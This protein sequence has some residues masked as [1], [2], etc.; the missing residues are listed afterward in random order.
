MLNICS[1]TSHQTGGL[2]GYAGAE[3]RSVDIHRNTVH[4]QPTAQGH[5]AV[6]L[7]PCANHT[8]PH[9]RHNPQYDVTVHRTC[10]GQE[11]WQILREPGES[12]RERDTH[13]ESRRSM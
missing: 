3:G 7:W 1:C 10:P 2:Q 8:E 9:S 5:V 4:R 12:I 13:V 11:C 6:R